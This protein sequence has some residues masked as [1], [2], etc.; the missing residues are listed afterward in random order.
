M[1]LH[2]ELG[3]TSFTDLVQLYVTSRQTV[4]VWVK[5]PEGEVGV[6]HV[7]DGELVHARFG[8]LL[9]RDAIRRALNLATGTFRVET[10][11]APPARNVHQKWLNVVLEETVKL[12]EEQRTGRQGPPSAAKPPPVKAAAEP[13]R[14]PAAPAKAPKAPPSAKK[15]GALAR[16]VVLALAVLVLAGA[17]VYLQKGPTL[18]PRPASPA[19]APAA[20]AAAPGEPGEIVLGMVGAFSGANRELGRGMKAGLELALAGANENGGVNGRKLK[21]VALDDGNEPTRAGPAMRELVD[22]RKVFAVVGNVG[23]PGAEATLPIALEKKVLFFGAMAGSDLLRRAPPDRYVFNFRPSYAEEAAAA[24]RYLLSVRHYK[25]EELAYFG[26]DDAY[27]EAGYSGLCQQM[28]AQGRDPSAV[29]RTRY[30]RNSLDVEEAAAKIGRAG[31]RLKGVVMFATYQ[32]AA[33]FIQRTKELGASVV[34][35]NDS[36][37]DSAALAESLLQ[38]R[39]PLSEDVLVT[40]V[41]PLPT[42]HASAVIRYREL[43]AAHALGE[44]PGSLS[45]EGYLAGSLLVEGLKRAGPAPDTEKVVAALE[46]MHDLDLGVGPR[47][48]FSATE[49]QASHKIWGTL[50]QPDGTYRN[51]DLE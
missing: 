27:G 41:V 34:Y 24:T 47:L 28:K 20:A 1:A 31:S 32:T 39:V 18:A 23:S 14:A 22:E 7:Q 3:E 33:R 50:L 51:V 5:T 44:A 45:L 17:A 36:E 46:G 2:G 6:F 35:T 25:P 26:Q 40:Q 38:A 9:G 37:V 48:G 4:A 30:R 13:A 29:L 10:N 43:L 12:D 8:E 49:H 16:T 11:V 15:G 19:A 42:S 21:L